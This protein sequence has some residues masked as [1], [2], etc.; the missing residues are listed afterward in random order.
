MG[1]LQAGLGEAGRLLA[2]NVKVGGVVAGLD[3]GLQFGL[4]VESCGN[5]L[6]LFRLS[7]A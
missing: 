4:G 7:L 3:L 2:G 6:D 1:D 5:C